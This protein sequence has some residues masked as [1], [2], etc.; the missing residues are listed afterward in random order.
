MR[1]LG[2]KEDIDPNHLLPIQQPKHEQTA[3][4]AYE[5]LLAISKQ[6][7]PSQSEP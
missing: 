6:W 7:Q 4:E 5:A 2:V 1:A 3:Q